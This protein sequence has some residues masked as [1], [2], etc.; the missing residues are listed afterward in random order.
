MKA[1]IQGNLLDD[2]HLSPPLQPQSDDAVR[3][4]LRERGHDVLV[5]QRVSSAQP[6]LATSARGGGREEAKNRR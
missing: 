5:L 3:W 1:K 2:M 4:C 6:G